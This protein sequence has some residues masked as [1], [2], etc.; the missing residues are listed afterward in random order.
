MVVLRILVG[1]IFPFT[2]TFLL[3]FSSFK[4]RSCLFLKL[5]TTNL[6]LKEFVC[7]LFLVDII[8]NFIYYIRDR[9]SSSFFALL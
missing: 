6:Q 4:G 8:S 5:V 1:Y 2:T 3:P 7:I 9:L